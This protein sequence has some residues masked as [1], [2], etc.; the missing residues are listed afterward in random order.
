VEQ[1][2][3]EWLLALLNT[4]QEGQYLTVGRCEKV[5]GQQ[6]LVDMALGANSR[7]VL[8]WFVITG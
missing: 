6:K 5:L 4:L 8:H 2:E 7:W 1:G 3:L